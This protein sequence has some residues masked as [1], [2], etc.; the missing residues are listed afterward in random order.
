MLQGAKQ[1]LWAPWQPEWT[2][3]RFPCIPSPPQ[4]LLC[5]P[6]GLLGDTGE[7]SS[8]RAHR[9]HCSHIYIKCLAKKLGR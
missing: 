8:L 9:K 6:E 7:F 4:R 3:R 1:S 2:M 5:Q